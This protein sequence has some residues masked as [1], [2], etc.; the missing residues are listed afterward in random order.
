MEALGEIVQ[1]TEKLKGMFSILMILAP[2]KG[3]GIVQSLAD[4]YDTVFP[5]WERQTFGRKFHF[6][7]RS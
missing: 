4:N 5:T 2:Q 3:K 7:A 1:S 6:R